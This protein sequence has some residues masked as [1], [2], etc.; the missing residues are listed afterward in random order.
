MT[1]CYLFMVVIYSTHLNK[2]KP[3]GQGRMVVRTYTEGMMITY[4]GRAK[5]FV[6]KLPRV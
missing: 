6:E 5:R 4:Q 3:S 1:K 2:K